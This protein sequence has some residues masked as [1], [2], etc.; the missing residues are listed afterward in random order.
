MVDAVEKGA[1][2][3]LAAPEPG[4]GEIFAHVS[5]GSGGGDTRWHFWSKSAAGAA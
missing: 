4:L 5:E 2:E 3:A 1:Q